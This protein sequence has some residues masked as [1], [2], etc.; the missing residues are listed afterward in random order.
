MKIN[1][2][3][4]EHPMDQMEWKKETEIKVT[5]SKEIKFRTGMYETEDRKSVVK[6]NQMNSWFFEKINKIARLTKEKRGRTQMNKI[7]NE[8]GDITTDIME[9]QR[10]IE[11]YYEQL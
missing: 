9:I 6:I 5:R 11:G 10:F 2:H 8:K 3:S 1:Q 4:A 7:R